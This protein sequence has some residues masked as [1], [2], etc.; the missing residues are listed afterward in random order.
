VLLVRDFFLDLAPVAA[1][2]CVL[3]SLLL[4]ETN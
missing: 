4:K 2:F 3:P 1:A